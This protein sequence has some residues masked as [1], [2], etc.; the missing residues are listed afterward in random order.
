[1][2]NALPPTWR[3]GSSGNGKVVSSAPQ[4]DLLLRED[5]AFMVQDAHQQ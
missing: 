2:L 3:Q 1:M 4:H 5:G